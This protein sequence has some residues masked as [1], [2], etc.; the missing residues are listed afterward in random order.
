MRDIR[1][2]P[3]EILAAGGAGRTQ[4]TSSV[5]SFILQNHLFGHE[6]AQENGSLMVTDEAFGDLCARSR[7]FA[8][9]AGNST[10]E[11]IR[12]LAD[13]LH[14]LF[15]V[16]ARR[17]EA[18]FPE[19]GILP[20][21]RYRLLDWAVFALRREVH[22]LSSDEAGELVRQMDRDTSLE[23]VKAFCAFLEWMRV[24]H[25]DTCYSV[26]VIPPARRSTSSAGEAY[27]ITVVAALYYY[28]FCNEAILQEDL[29]RRACE[30]EASAHAWLYLS[31]HLVSALRDTDL[32]RL[33]HP[34]LPDPPQEVL[35]NIKAGSYGASVY[36]EA[37]HTTMKRLGYIHME[38]NKTRHHKAVPELVLVIPQSLEPH[39][40]RLFLACE[41]HLQLSGRPADSPL[42]GKVTAYSRIRACLGE[43]IGSLFKERDASPVALARSYMQC[44]ETAG[45]A[46]SASKGLAAVHGYMLASMARSHKGGPAGFAETTAAYL[47]D[48]G[49]GLISPQQT[50]RELFDRGILSCLP[51]MLLDL[52]TDGAFKTLDFSQQA[53]MLRSLGLSPL[54]VENTMGL[55]LKARERSRAALK[56]A[57]SVYS[58]EERKGA[59]AK[60]LARVAG[61]HAPSKQPDIL[62]LM[63]ALGRTCPEPEAT[64]CLLCPFRIDTRAAVYHAA[65]ELHRLLR[66]ARQSVTPGERKKYTL[67]ARQCL[68]PVIQLASDIIQQTYGQE[69][70]GFLLDLLHEIVNN[71]LEN[72][73]APPSGD[74]TEASTGNTQEKNNGYAKP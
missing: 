68:L 55:V 1:D 35:Q 8:A 45:A 33:L 14:S 40:G 36:T 6:A 32:E 53:E 63:S 62:C 23:A 48:F 12:F 59:V 43:N 29:I 74:D 67:L 46:S 21:I 24:K 61:Y 28:L 54:D 17:L 25:R 37:V 19:C 58:P 16:T 64:N 15:P 57:L 66:L 20:R 50:A 49:L 73:P 5:L 3:G 38:P 30:S 2:I 18:F 22:L 13:T 72:S 27:G 52:I 34:A 41:A 47:K 10:D 11:K 7:I 44:L 42:F 65:G 9:H 60:A 39:F 4:N 51:S 70:S 56:E 31:I 26:T 71:G 69:S